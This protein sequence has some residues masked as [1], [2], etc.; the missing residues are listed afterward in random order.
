M[1]FHEGNDHSRVLE[2]GTFTLESFWAKHAH[3]TQS[4]YGSY[5]VCIC[6]CLKRAGKSVHASENENIGLLWVK[7]RR[8][9]LKSTDVCLKEVRCF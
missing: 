1:I 9:G 4:G 2:I 7:V 5:A 6:F 8:F 3:S